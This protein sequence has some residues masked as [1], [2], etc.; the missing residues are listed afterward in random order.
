VEKM[1]GKKRREIPMTGRVREILKEVSPVLFADITGDQVNYKF[2]EC[3]K[4]RLG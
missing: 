1:K 2:T 3:A 4:K